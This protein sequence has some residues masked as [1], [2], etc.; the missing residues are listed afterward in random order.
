M[1]E[2]WKVKTKPASLEARFEFDDFEKLRGFLDELADEAEKLDH[3]PNISF[4]REHASVIIY[5]K[6]DAL[7]DIDYA[8]AKSMDESFQ[9]FTNHS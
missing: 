5:S 2:R 7:Q 9:R 6:A 8:L 3:H 1:N 4:G